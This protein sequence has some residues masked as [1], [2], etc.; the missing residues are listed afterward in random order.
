MLENATIT[1]EFEDVE[2]IPV[3]IP[4]WKVANNG[5]LTVA[6][7]ITLTDELIQEG[8]ARIGESHQNVRKDK[9]FDLTDRIQVKILTNILIDSA[10]QNNFT[11]I[12]NETLT[13]SLE[14]VEVIEKN[15]FIEVELDEK[16]STMMS[17]EKLKS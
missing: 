12:C 7:D 14:I 16:V 17:V 4:G 3:D 13:S 2:I 5:A 10:I 9:D 15:I 6:L 1:L 8:I 11:Y